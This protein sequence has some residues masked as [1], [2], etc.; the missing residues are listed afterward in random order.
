VASYT[1]SNA[2]ADGTFRKVSVDCHGDAAQDLK[3]QVRKGYYA[4]SPGN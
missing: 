3:V 2:K 1:P 4:P